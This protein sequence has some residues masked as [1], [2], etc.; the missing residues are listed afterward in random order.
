MSKVICIFGDSITWG[1][2]DKELG[3][4]VNRLRLYFDNQNQETEIYN[5]GVDGDY[6]GDVLKRFN[7]EAQARNPQI[8]VLAIGINDSPHSSNPNGTNLKELKTQYLELIKK[9]KRFTQKIIILGPTNVDDNNEKGY[10]NESI[11]TVSG[12]IQKLAEKQ[13]LTFID[14]FGILS[15]DE[16]EDGLHPN[17]KGHQKIFEK[18]NEA[19]KEL[20]V[21]F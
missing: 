17:S 4:W 9:A 1:A 13:K 16:F 12:I 14:L 10:K 19:L 18:V 6:V 20:S 15:I 5:C 7:V 8:I 21:D 11:E 2:W 3:G